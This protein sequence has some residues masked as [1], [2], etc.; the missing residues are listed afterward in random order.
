M[1]VKF[2]EIS[3]R[4]PFRRVAF[5]LIPYGCYWIYNVSYQ[6]VSRQ[7]I[8]HNFIDVVSQLP[9]YFL[10]NAVA[11][12]T[13]TY[14]ETKKIMNISLKIVSIGYKLYSSVLFPNTDSINLLLPLVTLM[15]FQMWTDRVKIERYYTESRRKGTFCMP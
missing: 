15:P 14:F 4:S 13:A 11:F 3:E 2:N 7:G 8:L 5:K 1:N 6:R 9:A 10:F 12:S